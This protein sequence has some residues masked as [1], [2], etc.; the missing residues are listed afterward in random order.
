MPA[1]TQ[2]RKSVDHVREGGAN[3]VLSIY[4]QLILLLRYALPQT[5]EYGNTNCL[6][7]L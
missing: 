4:L 2:Q 5:S 1:S 7:S 3:S 6:Q